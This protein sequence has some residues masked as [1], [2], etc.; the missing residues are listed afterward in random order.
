[1]TSPIGINVLSDADLENYTATVHPAAV[2]FL[3]NVGGAIGYKQRHPDCLVISRVYDGHEADM[4]RT[5]GATLAYLE[6]RAGELGGANVFINLACESGMGGTDDVKLLVAEQVKAMTWALAHGVKVAGPHGSFY[7]HTSEADFL[8]LDPL[9]NLI[10]DHP[11]QLLLSMDEYAAGHMFSGVVDPSLPG[12]N[13]A[14]HIQPETWKASPIPKYWHVGSTTVGYTLHRRALG[15][16]DCEMVITEWGL[17]DLSDVAAWTSTFVKTSGYDHIRAWRSL[18]AQ[19]AAWYGQR[20]WSAERA[21]GEMLAACWREIYAPF[22]NIKAALIYC[23]GNNNDPQWQPFNIAGAHELWAI[24]ASV[25][26]GGDVM[27]VTAVPKPSADKLGTPLIGKLITPTFINLRNAPSTSAAIVK[28]L[29]NGTNIS[30]WPVTPAVNANGYDWRYVEGGGVSGWMA[31]VVS[32]WEQQII[33]PVV[34]P[35]APV[36]LPPLVVVPVPYVSQYGDAR[37][38]NGCLASMTAML[39]NWVFKE[40]STNK[41]LTSSDVSIAMNRADG[42]DATLAMVSTVSKTVY[43]ITLNIKGGTT[44]DLI[45]AE[46]DAGRPVGILYSR[47]LIPGELAIYSF[48]GSHGGILCGYGYTDKGERYFLLVEP[49]MKGDDPTPLNVLE[50]D[51]KAALVNPNTGNQ[52]NQSILIDPSALT[53]PPIP[54]EPETSLFTAQEWAE[55]DARILARIHEALAAQ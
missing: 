40:N 35:P 43:G 51:L 19:H 53:P 3:N 13:E 30:A 18:Q 49:L 36:F 46:L 47:G 1:M 22:G 11:G 17:D 31:R 48:A 25:K 4:Y 33:A 9:G 6:A 28:G 15:L 21:Y 44:P 24:L 7:G 14:G 42:K 38:A 34:T 5:P 10:A 50:S 37:G 23:L 55:I 20:G 29:P 41:V 32:T 54:P 2:L 12:G 45:A 16:K 27:T 39:D 52:P 8:A 26:S